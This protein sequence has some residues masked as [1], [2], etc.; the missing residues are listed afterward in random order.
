M[1]NHLH[2]L[3]EGGLSDIHLFSERLRRQ[4]RRFEIDRGYPLSDDWGFHLLQA[5]DLLALRRFFVYISRNPY[6]ASRN[7][8]PTGYPWSG[9]AFLFND[10]RRYFQSGIPYDILPIRDKRKIC[11]S[12]EV[13]LPSP[14][15]VA[16]GMILPESFL[17]IQRAEQFFK[18][19]NQYFSYLYRQGESDVEIAHLIGESILLPNDEVFSIVCGWYRVKTVKQLSAEQRLEA[20]KRMRFELASNPKQIS[21]VLRLPLTD[22]ERM[23]P[24]AQ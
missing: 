6:V 17:S 13:E 9:N 5:K 10:A 11:R 2:L 1:N 19:A 15:R 7:A 24:R 23:F 16:D 18:S 8:T 20:A 4:I 3:L 22:V 14:Y 12:H 21:Q